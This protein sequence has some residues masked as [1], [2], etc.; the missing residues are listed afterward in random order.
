MPVIWENGTAFILSHLRFA[1]VKV[2]LQWLFLQKVA[3]Y[4]VFATIDTNFS[5]SRR[6][7]MSRMCLQ[8]L[9]MEASTAEPNWVEV[10]S[11]QLNWQLVYKLFQVSGRTALSCVQVASRFS[12]VRDALEV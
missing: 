8:V 4:T 3:S 11:S 2:C 12:H 6:L 5:V 1:S 9:Q 10:G 7:P